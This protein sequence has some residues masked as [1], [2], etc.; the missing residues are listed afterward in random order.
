MGPKRMP[1]VTSLASSST[2]ATAPQQRRANAFGPVDPSSYHDFD[3]AMQD[4][5]ELE[6]KGERFQF[7]S[8]AQRFYDQAGTLYARAARLAATDP[9]RRADALY[10]ASRIQFLLATQFSLPPNNLSLLVEA[11]NTAEQAAQLAPPLIDADTADAPL[12]NPFTLDALTHLA[13]CLQTLG[14]AVQELGWPPQLR[15]PSLLQRQSAHSTTPALLWQEASALFQRVADGQAAIL[16][17]QKLAETASVEQDESDMLEP[18]PQIPQQD[19]LGAPEE[20]QDDVYGYTSSLVTPPSLVETLLSLMACFISLVEVAPSL[21]ELQTRNAAAEQVA[22]R[23]H[24]TISDS[25]TSTGSSADGALLASSS[26]EMRAKSGELERTSLALRVARIARAVELGAEPAQLS[27]ELES[28]MQAVHD[29]ATRLVAPLAADQASQVRQ[30]LDVPTLC[31]V[32]EAGQ[33]LCRLSLRLEPAPNA[34]AAI[35]TLATLSTKLY[36]QA[37]SALDTASR[38]GGSAAVL[39]QA[40]TSTPTSRARCRILLALSSFSL[41]RSHPAFEAAGI[42]GAMGTRSKLIDNAR[43]YA[44]KAA[45]EIG[46]GWILRP[47]A[48]RAP[49]TAVQPPPGGWESLSLEAEASMHLLRALLFRARFN[50]AGLSDGA[51]AAEMQ[52]ELV[53]LIQHLIQLRQRPIQADL[54][55]CASSTQLAQFMYGQGIKTFIDGIVDD[56][57]S[58][59]VQD[60]IPWWTE[61]LSGPLAQAP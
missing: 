5:V 7:G 6:E 30:D 31:D 26:E 53:Q 9:T 8:K 20:D 19:Q 27:N 47:A 25:M 18:E 60:E 51:A 32:G 3:E 41:F 45:T 22:A 46:L 36:S 38:G 1:K 14:E 2:S 57:G 40:N 21:P 10:N 17:D 4:G 58:N 61:L 54:T 11:V 52:N 13:T 44:R 35:W 55:A 33:N 39:G 23:V 16:K 42:P 34:V 29:W 15:P 37:L 43:L 56:H 48:S 12:P 24:E 28:A 49:T 50:A 59:V